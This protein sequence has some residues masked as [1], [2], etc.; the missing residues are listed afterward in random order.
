ILAEPIGMA[1]ATAEFLD[2]W[3]VPGE[4]FSRQWEERFG[5]HVYVPLAQAAVA[6]ALKQAGVGARGSGRPIVARADGRGGQRVTAAVGAKPGGTADDLA[7]VI[8]NT[9]AAHAGLLLADA[10]ERAAPDEV[11][12]Q[13]SL[14]DGADVIVWKT[15]AAVAARRPARALAERPGSG[16]S[17]SY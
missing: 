17:V 16:A 7:G 10:L 6:E 9:G 4:R 8:G 14:A 13:V 1:S 5:E 3:R 2:R 11:I 15:T 12:V